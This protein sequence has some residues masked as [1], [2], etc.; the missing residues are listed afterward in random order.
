MVLMKSAE[1]KSENQ[2]SV[3]VSEKSPHFNWSK[4]FRFLDSAKLLQNIFL[5]KS[6][7]TDMVLI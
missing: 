2:I 7:S 4:Y 1:N 3:A 6:S 5:V